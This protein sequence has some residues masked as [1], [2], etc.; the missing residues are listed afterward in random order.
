MV[1]AV[2]IFVARGIASI[3]RWILYFV[4][5][6]SVFCRCSDFYLLFYLHTDIASW[7]WNVLHAE[8][9]LRFSVHLI[10]CYYLHINIKLF[11][12]WHFWYILWW[13]LTHFYTN[14]ACLADLKIE[15]NTIYVKITLW[16]YAE[17]WTGVWDKWGAVL[18]YLS[19]SVSRTSYLPCSCGSKMWLTFLLGL[20]YLVYLRLV[21]FLSR[22]FYSPLSLSFSLTPP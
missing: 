12:V 13:I 15:S 19:F 4:F 9:K 18:L 8:D 21:L 20:Y 1:D 11:R 14:I 3:L 5:F 10:H 7:D 17:S 6:F 2:A 16:L 22:S